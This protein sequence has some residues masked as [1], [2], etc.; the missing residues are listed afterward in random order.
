MDL[1]GEITKFL[2]ELIDKHPET[3]D[4]IE[5]VRM[6]RL[7]RSSNASATLMAQGP[8]TSS[9]ASSSGIQRATS[10]SLPTSLKLTERSSST[11]VAAL[12]DLALRDGTH[13]AADHEDTSQGAV[14]SFQDEDGNWWT[15]AFDAQ[16]F[17]TAHALGSSR[18]LLEMIQH[19]NATHPH[20]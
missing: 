3:L 7:G 20:T 10:N 16:G 13:I 12:S 8:S 18:A 2:E 4:A 19:N 15:Y 11:A 14:H 9:T 5:N 17:G 6:N 1:K